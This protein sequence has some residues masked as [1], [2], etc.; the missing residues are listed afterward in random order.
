MMCEEA[1]NESIISIDLVIGG[2]Y[3]KGLFRAIIEINSKFASERNI[4]IIF[5][6]A[7]FHCKKYT[8]DI[9]VNTVMAPIGGRLNNIC[10]GRFLG[11]THEG[12]TQFI[13][14]PHGCTLP[15][16]RGKIICSSVRPRVFFTR[17]FSFYDV[18]LG[19]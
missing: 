10:A 17:F 14:L 3:G 5:R 16:P 15:P 4:T 12:K 18:V 9:L 7:H 11:W 8:G 19:K 13:I 6:L 1:K 2:D